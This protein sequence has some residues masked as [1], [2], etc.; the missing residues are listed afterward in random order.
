MASPFPSEFRFPRSTQPPLASSSHLNAGCH[1]VR[2][3]VTPEFV[4]AVTTPCGFDI[5]PTLSTRHQWFPCGPLL[6]SYL[7][8]FFPGLFLLRSRPRLLSIAA[9]GGLE[10]APA[11]RFREASSHQLSSYARL[12]RLGPS[13][14]WHTIIGI[15]NVDE[16]WLSAVSPVKLFSPRKACV[17]LHILIEFVQ[18]Y[19]GQQR[20]N[21][22]LYA[23]GNFEFERSAR[24]R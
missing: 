12:D 1:S 3:Q 16:I 2:K 14:S 24:Y 22:S 11:S 21:D 4:P 17:F 10:P 23:K 9:G 6:A 20:A 15:P 18:V 8:W 5:V 13:C 7:T 19:V